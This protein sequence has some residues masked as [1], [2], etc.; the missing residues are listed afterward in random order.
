MPFKKRNRFTWFSGIAVCIICAGVLF[1]WIFNIPI[2]TNIVPGYAYMKFNTALCM[3]ICGIS[4]LFL[5][6]SKQFLK[7]IGKILSI[8]AAGIG[9]LTLLEKITGSNLGTDKF[10]IEF[11]LNNGTPYPGSMSSAT[12]LNILFAGFCL[13]MLYRQVLQQVV[14]LLVFQI[15]AISVLAL[16]SNDFSSDYLNNF[17]FFNSMSIHTAVVFILFG[18][19][20]LLAPGIRTTRFPFEWKLIG[21][22]GFILFT[23]II[24]FYMFNKNNAS[25]ID[26]TEQVDH[27][28][29]VLYEAERIQ[30]VSRE[31][32]SGTRG[33]IITGDE[34]FLE[35]FYRGADSVYDDFAT[36]KHLTLN[37]PVQQKRVDTL[38]QLITD[39]IAHEKQLIDLK[40][41]NQSAEA[42][43]IIASGKGVEING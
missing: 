34:R 1:G 19:G 15:I 26:N 29:E 24:S 40:R 8:I 7:K 31:M 42:E 6:Q 9:F 32:E 36:L 3:F 12:A 4:L 25:F 28:R 30:T 21:G 23:M 41:K 17:P 10:F 39:H 43:K 13:Y 22:I 35:L 38:Q 27:T 20:I 5:L 37:N 33:F 2:L 18:A 11:V 14:Q 16:V